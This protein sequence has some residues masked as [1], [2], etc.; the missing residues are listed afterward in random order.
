MPQPDHGLPTEVALL[1]WDNPEWKTWAFI[2]ST[3]FQT[4]YKI[5]KLDGHNLKAASIL[6]INVIWHKPLTKVARADFSVINQRMMSIAQV[7]Y[8]TR[9][10]L[11]WTSFF[12]SS[13]CQ[14]NS[15]AC[16]QVLREWS[17]QSLTF[18]TPWKQFR[19]ETR[20]EVLCIQG[21][22]ES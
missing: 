21:L 18:N 14:L 4:Y 1:A 19:A 11:T 15:V 9:Y 6:K 8:Q 12:I 20:H 7:K 2:Y 3:L 10:I 17:H 22:S 5:L 16:H 13:Y